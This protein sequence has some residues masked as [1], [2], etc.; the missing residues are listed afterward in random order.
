MDWLRFHVIFPAALHPD[1]KIFIAI[2]NPSGHTLPL[3]IRAIVH[4]LVSYFEKCGCHS[5]LN[6]GKTNSNVEQNAG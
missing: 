5:V 6:R 4:A 3:L 1:L 2:E